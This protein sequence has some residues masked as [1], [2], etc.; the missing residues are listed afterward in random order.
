MATSRVGADLEEQA[1]IEAAQK[2]DPNAFGCLVERYQRFVYNLAL[3]AVCHAGEAEDM[4]QEAFVRAWLA[5]PH[6]RKEAKFRTWLY[7]IV[8]NLCYNRLEHLRAELEASQDVPELEDLPLAAE[9]EAGSDP[10]SRLEQDEMKE[11]LQQQVD[12]LPDGYRMMVL[13]RY[14][15]DMPYEE[16]AMAMSLPL[17]TVKTGLF[18]AKGMLRQALLKQ[19]EEVLV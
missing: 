2:G 6:F 3:R 19:Y 1:W 16:I 11:Y 15:E 8:V 7:R 12:N 17:G 4:A 9:G 10:H 18:R 14:V 5:L 13:M